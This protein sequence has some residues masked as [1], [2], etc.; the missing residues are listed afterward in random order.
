MTIAQLPAA[1]A[2]ADGFQDGVLETLAQIDGSVA[3]AGLRYEGPVPEELQAW[4]DG[5]RE[6]IAKT[7]T[8][9]VAA[10]VVMT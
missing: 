3:L 2:Y 5:I 1:I 6:N 7:D 10:G 9:A 8:R 4:I